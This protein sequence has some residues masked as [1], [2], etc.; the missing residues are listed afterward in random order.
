L[1]TDERSE[2]LYMLELLLKKKLITDLEYYK[3]KE[4]INNTYK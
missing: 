4:K 3:A 1:I 2:M